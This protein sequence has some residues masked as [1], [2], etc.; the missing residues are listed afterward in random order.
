M[1]PLLAEYAVQNALLLSAESQ[2]PQHF[3]KLSLLPPFVFAEYTK[4]VSKAFF[5]LLKRPFLLPAHFWTVLVYFF[6]VHMSSAM[7]SRF[8]AGFVPFYFHIVYDILA[9]YHL[10]IT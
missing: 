10:P 9:T 7:E 3:L 1:L 4:A 2:Q 6:F 5:M 8:F